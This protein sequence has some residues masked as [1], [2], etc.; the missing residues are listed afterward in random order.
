[1]IRRLLIASVALL[2]PFAGAATARADEVASRCTGRVIEQPFTQFGDLADYFLAPDGDLSA[3]GAGWDLHGA[4]VVAENEPFWVHGDGT[5]ASAWLDRGASAISPA[6]CV[7]LDDPTMR[8]FARSAGGPSGLLAVDVLYTDADGVRQELRIGTVSAD[9]AEE[10]T[11]VAPLAIV[12][13]TTEMNVQFRFTALG[14]G[15]EWLID[16]VYVDPYKKG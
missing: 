12:A 5:P 10:W 4:E 8:F 6:I 11:P 3:G 9:A 7:T 16:D 2:L 15:S 13:N 14:A 1:M